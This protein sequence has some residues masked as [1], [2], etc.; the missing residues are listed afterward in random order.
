MAAEFKNDSTGVA[1]DVETFAT[2][3]AH[4]LV[5]EYLAYVQRPPDWNAIEELMAD[6]NPPVWSGP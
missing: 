5:D 3:L 2:V 6:W 4:I 1:D